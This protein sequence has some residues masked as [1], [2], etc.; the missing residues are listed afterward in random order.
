MVGGLGPSVSVG[1]VSGLDGLRIGL[2]Q[3]GAPGRVAIGADD[4]VV[5]A[6]AVVGGS[7][8]D[9]MPK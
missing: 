9:F 6:L 3:R 8:P 1:L 2:G 5:G 7:L 4:D